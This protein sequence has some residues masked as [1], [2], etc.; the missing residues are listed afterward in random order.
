[1]GEDDIVK[2][3][4]DLISASTP[5]ITRTISGLEVS[6]S[7][8]TYAIAFSSEAKSTSKTTLIKK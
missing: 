7:G 2:K 8:Q 6:L 1:M 5:K 4:S 3:F